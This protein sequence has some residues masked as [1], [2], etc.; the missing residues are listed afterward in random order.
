[1]LSHLSC[2][3]LYE[4]NPGALP[5]IVRLGWGGVN[6]QSNSGADQKK[7][8]SGVVRFQVNSGLVC[9]TRFIVNPD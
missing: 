4:S 1:M 2:F 9:L 6:A 3:D 5:Q 8:P 7:K